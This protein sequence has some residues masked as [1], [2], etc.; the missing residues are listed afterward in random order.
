MFVI[1]HGFGSG[2]VMVSQGFEKLGQMHSIS[3]EY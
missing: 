2:S 1:D 3:L